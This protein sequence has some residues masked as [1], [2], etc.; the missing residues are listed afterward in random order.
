MAKILYQHIASDACQ[1]SAKEY[2]AP[3]H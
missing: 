3:E 2:E 1:M